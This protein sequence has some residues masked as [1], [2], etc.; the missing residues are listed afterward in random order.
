MGTG[1]PFPPVK[2]VAE[3][4]QKCLSIFKLRNFNLLT[5]DAEPSLPTSIRDE[6][7]NHKSAIDL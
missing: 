7:Y 5:N 3:S 2:M 4:R 6:I 1:F